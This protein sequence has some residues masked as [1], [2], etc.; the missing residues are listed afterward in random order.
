MYYLLA[1]HPLPALRTSLGSTGLTTNT[2]GAPVAEMRYCAASLWDKPCPLRS[3]SG[4]HRQGE[5]RASNGTTPTNYTYT[6][7][8]S[9]MGDFGLMF[10]NARWYDPSIGRF[11]QVDTIIPQQQGVQAWD[12]YAYSN[13]NPARYTDLSGHCAVGFLLG[14]FG[15]SY[16]CPAPLDFGP[17]GDI[18]VP[19]EDKGGA[20]IFVPVTDGGGPDIFVPVSGDNLPDIFVTMAEDNGVEGFDPV[21]EDTLQ[22]DKVDFGDRSDLRDSLGITDPNVQAHHLIPWDLRNHPL[23]QR[24]AQAGWQMNEAYNGMELSGPHAVGGHP[25]YNDYVE[26]LLDSYYDP[27]MTAEDADQALM[28]VTSHMR[29][30]IQSNDSRRMR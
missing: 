27:E 23:V 8:Y 24:G 19:V 14:L 20:D 1:D 6:G 30:L 11:A 25:N 26:E 9:N 5:V 7:Q 12:R 3:A 21:H 17:S 29:Y 22:A 2:S 10:Y 4:M 16:F 28:H 13:N 18:F 15:I